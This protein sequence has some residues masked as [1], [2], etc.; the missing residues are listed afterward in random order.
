MVEVEIVFCVVK[1]SFF[2]K[3]NIALTELL[4]V[5]LD[6]L[7]FIFDCTRMLSYQIIKIF[8]IF[9]ISLPFLLL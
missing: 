8:L 1:R 2:P 4:D 9:L 3:I 7:F 6:R 5:G